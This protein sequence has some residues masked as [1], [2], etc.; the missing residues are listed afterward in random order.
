MGV[1]F[2]TFSRF[3]NINVF[4]FFCRKTIHFNPYKTR[5]FRVARSFRTRIASDVERNHCTLATRKRGYSQGND[6]WNINN[7]RRNNVQRKRD[8][9]LS[10]F[11]YH[12]RF[13][14]LFRSGG[15]PGIFCFL[16]GLPLLLFIHICVGARVRAWVSFF[17]LLQPDVGRPENSR[18][19]LE[20]RVVRPA[21]APMFSPPCYVQKYKPKNNTRNSYTNYYNEGYRE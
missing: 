11:V 3:E 7:I 10:A 15:V 14:N 6:Q 16:H 9:S 20:S 13:C 12:F 18:R 19:P 5:R 17:I 1:Y 4:F 2:S 8:R 21:G